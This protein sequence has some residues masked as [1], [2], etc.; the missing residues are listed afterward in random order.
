MVKPTLSYLICS[1]PRSGTTLLCE[2]LTNTGI[3]GHPEEYYQHRRRTGLP[4]RPREYF[5]EGGETPEIA[6]I[7]GTYSRVD[8]ELAV[9]DPRRF[10]SYREYLDWTIEAGTTPNGVFGAKV[11]WDYF[12]GFVDRLRDVEGNAVMT[13]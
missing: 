1:T 10:P 5:E 3:A 8:E 2:A 4:R 9:Y 7:L 13:T 12:N 11:M 6:R